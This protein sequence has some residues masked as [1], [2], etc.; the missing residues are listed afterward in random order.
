LRSHAVPLLV[1]AAFV[2]FGA[3]F[4]GSLFRTRP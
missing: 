4:V 3:F 2:P 1:M